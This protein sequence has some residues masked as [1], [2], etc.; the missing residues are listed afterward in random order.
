[1]KTIT[2]FLKHNWILLSIIGILAVTVMI[3]LPNNGTNETAVKKSFYK[4]NVSEAEQIT[5]TYPQILSTSY[6]SNEISHILN[7]PEN[8]PLIFSFSK[9]KNEKGGVLSYLDFTQTITNVP[10]VKLLDNDEKIIFIDGD[11]ENYLSIHTIYKNE[12]VSSYT[13][14]VNILGIP[15]GSLGM[16]SCVGY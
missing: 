14:N 13:K 15:M 10:L 4:T 16:G 1:M 6:L 12:G 7:K 5:C 9:Y 8:N 3:L 2:N 11:A